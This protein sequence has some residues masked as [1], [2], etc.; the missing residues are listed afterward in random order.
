MLVL[1][2]CHLRPSKGVPSRS[3]KP[4]R[5][6]QGLALRQ[7]G[8]TGGGIPG[9]RHDRTTSRLTDAIEIVDDRRQKSRLSSTTKPSCTS[10][11]TSKAAPSSPPPP[12]H[13]HAISSSK[14]P[15]SSGLGSEPCSPLAQQAGALHPVRLGRQLHLIYDGA[16]WPAVRTTMTPASR[17]PSARPSRRCLTPHFPDAIRSKALTTRPS[18]TVSLFL[19]RQAK[20]VEAG[21]EQLE[22]R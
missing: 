9:S 13:P 22:S 21:Q 18:H 7:H 8:R 2:Q 15:S 12:R 17:L 6:C 5:R 4:T 1:R 19:S 20:L 3:G 14:P 10:G 11:Q 16:G